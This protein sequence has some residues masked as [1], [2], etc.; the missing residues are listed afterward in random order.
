MIM[1]G[2]GRRRP[3]RGLS[4]NQRARGGASC[5]EQAKKADSAAERSVSPTGNNGSFLMAGKDLTLKT[6]LVTGHL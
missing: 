4:R 2:A 3:R 6:H 5:G 1:M